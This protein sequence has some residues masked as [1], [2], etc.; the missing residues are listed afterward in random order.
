[1]PSVIF[2]CWVTI[3]L[4]HPTK[5]DVRA[6]DQVCSSVHVLKYF[7]GEVSPSSW[8]MHQLMPQSEY[9]FKRV[10]FV[11]SEAAFRR[12]IIFD[13]NLKFEDAAPKAPVSQEF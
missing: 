1:M 7:L 4:Y 2:H 12:R 13:S 6:E 11:M 9:S 5:Y 10:K 3:L 8:V